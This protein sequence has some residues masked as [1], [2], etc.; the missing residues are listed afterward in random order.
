MKHIQ[1]I[2]SDV[3]VMPLL[4]AL[5]QHPEL[6]D[7]F[8]ARKA[9]AESPHTAM[10]DIWVRYNDIRKF[11]DGDLTHFNNEH[12]P[13]W[14]PAYDALPQLRPIIF[15]LM[16]R[17]EAVQL[18]G[19]LITKIPPGGRIEPHVDAGW[20]VEHYNTKLYVVLQSNPKCFN[21]VGD[22][23]VSMQAGEVWW[24][25]NTIEHEVINDGDDDRITLIVCTRRD[26]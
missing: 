23:V 24:F 12:Y 7:E 17:V 3:D 6:W 14:Y 22:D 21:R 9:A 1:K 18:G 2:H 26:R 8:G 20:H 16:A 13:I 19:V 4:L 10:S 25:D 11:P 15:G 5:K